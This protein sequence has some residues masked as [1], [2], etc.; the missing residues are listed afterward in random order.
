M[1]SSPQSR[2]IARNSPDDFER[3]RL[4]MLTQVADPISTR[5]LTELGVE[6]GWR[7][8]EAGAGDGSVARWLADRVGP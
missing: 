5:R 6:P 3:E 2:Y 1:S 4:A 8:L 7:C